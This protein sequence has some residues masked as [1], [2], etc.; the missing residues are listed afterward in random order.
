MPELIMKKQKFIHVIY[1]VYMYK[2]A[3][4][5]LFILTHTRVCVNIISV[6][7]ADFLFEETWSYIIID[8]VLPR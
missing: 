8:Q 6:C 5:T 3:Q 1:N 4:Q 2:S 7:C